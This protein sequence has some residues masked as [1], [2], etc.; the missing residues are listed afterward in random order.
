MEE[1]AC[2]PDSCLSCS[3]CKAWL[4]EKSFSNH[5]KTCPA[6]K[7]IYNNYLRNSRMLISPFISLD[8]DDDDIENLILQMRETAQNPGL[9]NICMQDILIKEFC[10]GLLHKLGTEDAKTM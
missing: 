6:G 2:R 10:R 3:E 1:N 9:R 4:Y 5:A 8:S 7:P